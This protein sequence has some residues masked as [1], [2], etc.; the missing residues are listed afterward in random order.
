MSTFRTVITIRLAAV[1]AAAAL[2]PPHPTT[3]TTTNNNN[4]KLTIQP[5]G[6]MRVGASHGLRAP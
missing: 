6:D 3:T 4:T 1:A 2:P 5:T